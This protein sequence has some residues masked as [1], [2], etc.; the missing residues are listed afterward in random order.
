[1]STEEIL[2]FK[3]DENDKG[4]RVDVFC[5]ENVEDFG[6][7]Y[8]QYI[9]SEENILLNNKKT[10]SSKKL[11]VGDTVTIKLIPPKEIEVEPQDI[12]IDILYEDKDII[13]VNKQQGLV[14]H[15]A[16][17][18]VDGT[19]VNALLFHTK[20]L[21]GING[22]LRPG[23][24]HR[25]DK[26]TSGILVIAKNNNAHTHL[27]EQLQDH[28]MNRE[29]V[30]LVKGDLDKN[31]GTINLPLGRDPK[32]R[33]KRAVTN[34]N[35]KEAVTH[36]EVLERYGK[37]TLCKFKLETGRTHQIRVH[38]KEIGHPIAGDPLYGGDKNNPFK[39]NGQ[40]LHAKKLGFI[41]PATGEYIEFESELP[42]Y[43]VEILEKL[44]ADI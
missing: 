24:V 17:G 29:Y 39:T 44:R 15:P 22:E 12:D 40:L 32:N 5:T 13:V 28:S 10:K 25:I 6:R 23:I 4:K 26:D 27:S 18:N 30:A 41:H 3:I 9:I 16:P 43:F 38:M 20:D 7:T 21:S 35:S 42:D 34:I 36:Y 37:Y 33:I 14:V 19:L 1:M 11:K 31:S 8:V 2:E